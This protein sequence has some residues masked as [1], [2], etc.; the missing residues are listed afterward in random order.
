[1]TFLCIIVIEVRKV[2]KRFFFLKT[3]CPM[4]DH[5]V[6]MDRCSICSQNKEIDTKGLFVE[7]GWDG[8]GDGL[9]H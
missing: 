7:C 1:M 9:D 2:E 8:E 4:V 5:Q 3:Y 6:D